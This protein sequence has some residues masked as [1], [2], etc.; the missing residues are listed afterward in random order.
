[1]KKLNLAELPAS[2]LEYVQALGAEPVALLH[3]G[4]P[5][6][7]LLPTPNSDMESISLGLNPKFLAMIER[8]KESLNRHGGLSTEEVRRHLSLPERAK[9]KTNHRKPGVKKSKTKKAPSSGEAD[10]SQV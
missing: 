1:M 9:K 3:E 6:A 7:V 2:L 5:V 8:S 10:G 4:K